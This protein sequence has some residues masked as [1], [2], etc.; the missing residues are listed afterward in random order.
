MC[1]SGG[2]KGNMVLRTVEKVQLGISMSWEHVWGESFFRVLFRK[3]KSLKIK[4]KNS[5]SEV[6]NLLE[7]RNSSFVENESLK[8]KLKSS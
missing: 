2:V 4:W 1:M 5:W 6:E 3:I 7:V 8:K